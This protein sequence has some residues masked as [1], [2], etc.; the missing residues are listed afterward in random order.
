[1]EIVKR[2]GRAGVAMLFLMSPN[3]NARPT[4]ISVAGRAV[5]LIEVQELI[6]RD[7]NRNGSLDRYED[8]RL[9]PEDRA[10]DLVCSATITVSG[11]R[12]F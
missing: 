7:L 10:S 4:Q 6:F 11:R 3:L 8:W 1:M 2:V 12:Q 9:S 5:P